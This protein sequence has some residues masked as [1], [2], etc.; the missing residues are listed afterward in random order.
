MRGSC[1]LGVS[2]TAPHSLS[3]PEKEGLLGHVMQ[4]ETLPVW[5]SNSK[6]FIDFSHNPLLLAAIFFSV[7]P[8]PLVCELQ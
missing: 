2:V 6:T 3:F 5:N 7:I 1:L 4:T 8:H